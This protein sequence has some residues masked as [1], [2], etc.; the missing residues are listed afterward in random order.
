MLTFP[1]PLRIVAKYYRA[2]HTFGCIANPTI[3]IAAE[4]VN[5]DYCDCPDGSDEPGTSACSH[6]SPLSPPFPVD[7]TTGAVNT[8]NVLPGF[9]CKN[10][11]HQPGYVA[12]L[13]VNDG[14]CDYDVCCDGSDEWD[15][16]G[17][18]NCPDKCME[19]GKEWRKQSEQKKRAM[20]DASKKQKE[21]VVEASRLKKEVEDRISDLETNVKGMATKVK[22]LEVQLQEVERR[23]RGKIVQSAGKGSKVTVLAGLAKGRIEEL[24]AALIDIRLQRDAGRKRIRELEA[25]LTTFKAEYNP[26]FNDEGV[27]R[28]VRGWEEYAARDPVVE[29]AARD[30]DLEEMSK[31]DHEIDGIKWEEWERPD[32][33]DVELRMAPLHVSPFPGTLGAYTNALPV[34]QFEAYLPRPLREWLD[35]QL[36]DLRIFLVD[37][38]ILA[39]A[40]RSGSE[41]RAVTDAR[42]ALQSAQEDLTRQR[43]QLTDHRTDLARDYGVGGVFRALKGRCIAVDSGEYSYEMCW[44]DGTTQKSKRGGA[45]TNM[46]NFVRLDSIT[47]DEDG[48]QGRRVVLRYE[49]G[50]HCWNGPNRSTMVVLACADREAVWKVVEEEK[51]VYRMEVGTPAVCEGGDGGRG[52]AGKDEL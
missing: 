45:D 7:S 28:A 10:K 29:D 12:F 46:G 22:D 38:G 33:N 15:H 40:D 47:V 41:S 4:K 27:K 26:N 43:D 11:G 39:A 35:R 9:Y 19:I 8:T 34:Y 18:V 52:V 32:E 5:D 25:L 14:I 49:N 20:S 51:C 1:D 17:G 37:N 30:R 13:S 31:P 21:L 2:P 3:E 24:R 42:K 23:E 16:V 6:I 36:Q 48:G 44:L 50:Q